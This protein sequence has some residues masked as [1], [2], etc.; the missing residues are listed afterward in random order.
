[1][2]D[3]KIVIPVMGDS[4]S[5]YECTLVA[6][7]GRLALHCTCQA[8]EKGTLC[9]HRVELLAGNYKRAEASGA[10]GERLREFAALLEGSGLARDCAIV[11]AR[12]AEAEKKAAEIKKEI[13]TAKKQLARLMDEGVG[14]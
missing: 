1:M 7:G 14:N 13:S 8:G 12:I 4:G 10:P 6:S 9:K 3:A 2:K 5:R 11:G